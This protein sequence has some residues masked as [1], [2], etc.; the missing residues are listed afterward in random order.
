MWRLWEAEKAKSVGQEAVPQVQI[1]GTAKIE[2][3][4]SARPKGP[5]VTQQASLR[6]SGF[7]GFPSVS[8]YDALGRNGTRGN[9]RKLPFH[10]FQAH[11][12]LDEAHGG[13]SERPKMDVSSVPGGHKISRIPKTRYMPFRRCRRGSRSYEQ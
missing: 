2:N 13:A 11:S 6:R 7:K 3:N 12:F 9:K 5:I 1:Y 4:Y 10:A 8:E